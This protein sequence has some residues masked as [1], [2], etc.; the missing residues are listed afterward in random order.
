MNKTDLNDIFKNIST[1]T[2][3][4]GLPKKTFLHPESEKDYYKR[5]STEDILGKSRKNL[6]FVVPVTKLDERLKSV[7]WKKL[8]SILPDLNS[9]DCKG[10]IEKLEKKFLDARLPN[11]KTLN[12]D[13][14]Q[15]IDIKL[16][17]IDPEKLLF[18]NRLVNIALNLTTEQEK[19]ILD[20]SKEFEN[21]KEN[22]PEIVPQ[23]SSLK[24]ENKQRIKTKGE[25]K[26][27]STEESTSDEDGALQQE[28]RT[29][30]RNKQTLKPTASKPTTQQKFPEGKK[31]TQNS[32]RKLK[33]DDSSKVKSS[34]KK[35]RLMQEQQMNQ[36]SPHLEAGKRTK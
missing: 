8:K 2:K 20:F 33:D 12:E 26:D 11:E 23:E 13:L 29:T 16:Q 28:S 24:Q 10:I 17:K 1:M 3:T 32:K 14:R 7:I 4:G 19:A 36:H 34:R 35:P 21:K 25:L 15:K 27:T 18:V 31:E 30:N 5:S 9:F 6:S 22:N